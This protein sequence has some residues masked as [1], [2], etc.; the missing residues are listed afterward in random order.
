MGSGGWLGGDTDVEG[1]AE[2]DLGDA[3]YGAGEEV[4]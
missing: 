2:K 1:L 3:A 4:F